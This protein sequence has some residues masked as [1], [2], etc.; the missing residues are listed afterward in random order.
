MRRTTPPT[1]QVFRRRRAVAAA[2]ALSLLT[3]TAAA[4]LTTLPGGAQQQPAPA[5]P[6]ADPV[7]DQI[8]AVQADK[9]SRTPDEA[10]V[11]SNLLYAAAEEAGL[12]AVE[13][14]PGLTSSAEVDAAG[15]TEVDIAGTIDDA[16]LDRIADLGGRVVESTPE[17]DAVRAIVP[18]DALVDLAGDD[19]VR[20]IAPA[21]EA[22]TN[23]AEAPSGPAATSA[24]AT[25]T[26]GQ[27]SVANEA[28]VTHGV[29]EVRARFGIDGVGVKACVLSDGVDTLAGRQSS[30]DLPVVEILPGQ[31][32]SGDEGTAM[33][34]LIH[35][36]APGADLAFATAFGSQ[37]GFAQ[38]IIDLRAAGCDVIVDDVTYYTEGAFQDDDVARAITQVR[39]DGAVYFTSA[40]N[41]GNLADGTSGTWQG[42]FQDMGPSQAPLP[43]GL[44]VH[45]W[46]VGQTSNLVTGGFMQP[47]T[48]QWADPLG[49][50][51]NDYDLFVLNA[52][53]TG[54]VKA[55]TTKQ[56]GTQDPFE[57]VE[58][59]N[60][61]RIV[62][63][64]TAGAADRY[65]A[66]YTNRGLLQHAT[67]GSSY[68]HNSSV[69][70]VS[71]GA[72]P[73]VTSIDGTD[74]GPY[75]G[76][77][78]TADV[79][80]TFSGDGPAR[81]FYAPDGTPLTPGNLGSTGGRARNGV[82]LTAADGTSTSA[83]AFR[84]FY[85]T[86]AAAPN[87][88][89]L[90]V[91]ALS[92][93]P[94]LT[95]DQ[96][97]AALRVAAV[98]VEVPGTDPATGVGIPLAPA[99]MAEIGMDS[100][101]LVLPGERTVT[102][103][104]GDG[105]DVYEPGEVFEVVQDLVNRGSEPAT[106][107][108][109]TLS[110]PSSSVSVT[111]SESSYGTVAR[112]A[113]AEPGRVFKV[114]ILKTCTCGRDI[115]FQLVTSYDGG[116]APS[117]TTGF[118]L[119][120]GTEGTTVDVARTGTP[121]AI[122][123]LAATGATP[124]PVSTTIQVGDIGG[125]VS[126]LDVTFGGTTCSST[127]GS[128][129]VGLTHSFVGD[130]EMTLTSP[131]GTTVA[132]TTKTTNSGNNLCRTVFSDDAPASFR[133]AT[134]TA[135][136]YTGRYRPASPLAAFDGEDA[137][138]TWTLRLADAR[139]GDT[140]SLRAVS[141][142]LTPASCDLLDTTPTAQAD[143]LATPYQT[144]LSV[145][146]PGVLGNDTDAYG[147]GIEATL[148]DDVDHGTLQL[149]EDG[150]LSYDPD[151]GFS[152]EDSFRYTAHDADS[153]SAP[154][155]VTID[156]GPAPNTAPTG[157]ADAY[158]TGHAGPLTVAAP[159]VLANDD[160]PEGDTR[161]ATL[162]DDVDH[163]DLAL[164]AD[165]SFR[166]TPD[167][168]FGGDDTFTYVAS[169][170]E[171]ES[172]ETTVTITVA[173]RTNTAPTA[174]GDAY[175]TGHGELL[176]VTAPGVLA[177][178]D[179]AEDDALTTA[180]VDDV[181]HGDL[182]LAADGSFTYVPDDGF[183]GED[184]FTYV[185]G[186]GFVASEP[187][188]VTITVADATGPDPVAVAD[189]FGTPYRTNYT[190]PAPGL[191][192]NDV[193]GGSMTAALATDPAHGTVV[194]RADGSFTYDPVDTYKGD[195]TFTYRT[196]SGGR[197]SA[198]A[199]VTI[200]VGRPTD[201]AP[202]ARADAYDARGGEQLMIRRPGVLAN[203]V[204]PDGQSMTTVVVDGVD[205][206]TLTLRLDGSFTY[207]PNPGFRGTDRFT[208][209]AR[210]GYLLS[211]PVVVEL[212]VT[213]RVDAFVDVTHRELLGRP[214]TEAEIQQWVNLIEGGSE[215]RTTFVRTLSL[216]REHA[217]IIVSRT[218]L[219]YLGRP[220]TPAEMTTWT[221]KLMGGMTVA[222]LPLKVTV[223]QNGVIRSA[224]TKPAL[225]DAVYAAFLD[226]AP[227]T[228][229]RAR[230]VR[231]LQRDETLESIARTLHNSTAGRAR[232]IA[233]Q[234]A[235]VLG[236]EPTSAEM[237]LWQARLSTKDERDLA[238]ALAASDEY[239]AAVA[240]P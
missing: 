43:T 50:S 53:G 178:D 49:A 44:R 21:A 55:S 166:Y 93:D 112:N 13:G 213:S 18:V 184:V 111:A 83:P 191:L 177:D 68:G 127:A 176:A 102:E 78:S 54:L 223:T 143:A 204:D 36:M 61:Q 87:A 64:R 132:L 231:A 201:A 105:D 207:L 240:Q 80:E 33:L 237:S 70:A 234:F 159:G 103:R 76:Q 120:V 92:A 187:A 192:R 114:R 109:A 168:G 16:L 183:A 96:V 26:T 110:S 197:W 142:Q 17:Q 171:L 69:D 124:T 138:G 121:L 175:A 98:D 145:G 167:A 12:P 199:T 140:G 29:D 75:P 106:N 148:V 90:A 135:A 51:R 34:E 146:D 226:R 125:P 163:G 25:G 46:G 181:E 94:G 47:V 84:T 170:G 3:G 73:A 224:A 211:A 129:T 27:G 11:D 41:S 100:A 156:V 232:R 66:V 28:V 88:A 130:L 15:R 2:V 144:P 89:A 229:E 4:V 152:G 104:L 195:D 81:S 225:I 37:A 169:D 162:I 60:G 233:M 205:H 147:D 35:D 8:A 108:T 1:Q 7:A 24:T 123:D 153:S 161:T 74:A 23:H 65:L 160:D 189:G 209:A 86:S 239:L 164:A 194:V 115:P 126:G 174:S 198:P 155:V 57:R 182:V 72:T 97:E 219:T 117:R 40:G 10:K 58:A 179:D 172:I 67:G 186:D 220:A 99:V 6:L 38:N 101:A 39:A 180:L 56:T 119:V 133:T 45:G 122:P 48:L 95:P 20:A 107:V 71:V 42:D 79:T 131:A 59:N 218:F 149:D 158:G 216:R 139:K 217:A 134:A 173:P 128:T 206:G 200:S 210:D 14:A 32:G 19:D 212:S 222:E 190:A 118:D 154:A 82:D 202:A 157:R 227:T 165:G 151:A 141:L 238:I 203:D 91:L 5:T 22:R 208:Y 63:T 221:D 52:A 116:L 214:A 31:A 9:A 150:T 136:P 236:R 196:R 215:T 85:G 30:G 185:A 62:V 235:E 193:A 230:G 188:T 113:A 77:H 228:D 137:E